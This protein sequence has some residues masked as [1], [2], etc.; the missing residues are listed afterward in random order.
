MAKMNDAKKSRKTAHHSTSIESN[1]GEKRLFKPSK[2]FA[3]KA[4][5]S[6]ME[7]YKKLYRASIKDP[8]KFFAK[9]AEE[10]HWFKKWKKVLD[11]KNPG[12]SKA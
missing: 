11:L 3:E 10:L 8:E 4:R 6:S 1:L 2:K 5:I 12:L 9:Q 7:Q